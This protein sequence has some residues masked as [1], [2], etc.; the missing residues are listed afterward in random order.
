MRKA[1][2]ARA[3]FTIQS[4]VKKIERVL[5]SAIAS[6]EEQLLIIC[7]DEVSSFSFKS[8][9]LAVYK[10]KISNEP[11]TL[12]RDFFKLPPPGEYKKFSQEE[13]TGTKEYIKTVETGSCLKRKRKKTI[14]EDIKETKNYCE[15]MLPDADNMARQWGDGITQM[16]PGLWD[17]IRNWIEAQLEVVADSFE[18][19]IKEIFD[20]ANSALEEQLIVIDGDFQAELEKW[21][22][23]SSEIRKTSNISKKLQSK[24]AIK[25]SAV[26]RE[27]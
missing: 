27:K 3:E 20:L 7:P 26:G 23:I 9:V 18:D 5:S 2:I 11:P 8:N 19:S 12:P 6:A 4:Q 13:I 21:K 17:V 24:L 15:I 25:N 22:Q 16:K 1:L 10:S 14:L